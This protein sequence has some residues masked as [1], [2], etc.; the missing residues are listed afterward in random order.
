MLHA[1]RRLALPISRRRARQPQPS[2]R[3]SRSSPRAG[4]YTVTGTCGLWDPYGTTASGITVYQDCPGLW[5]RNIGGNFTTPSGQGGGW[6]FRAPAGTWI[7]S[8]SLQGPMLGTGGWQVAGYLEGGSGPGVN[9]ENC[10]GSSCPGAYKYL[11]NSYYANGASGIVMRLR[12][13][14]RQLPQQPRHHRLLRH[15]RRQRHPR[16]PQPADRRPRRRL[17]AQR[18]LEERHADRSSSTPTTTPASRSTAPHSTERLRRRLAGRLQL[19]SKGAVPERRSRRSRCQRPAWRTVRTRSAAE[20]VDASG[21]PAS[22][23]AT[24]YADNTPPTQP[25]DVAGRRRRGVARERH[26]RR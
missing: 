26:V 21:N 17:A 25:L 6:A 12:C 24:I 19:R 2:P 20:A 4:T 9:F 10:P 11:N 5:A 8:F 7:N 18:R 23:A 3:A 1:L 16:R 13:G 14:A 22:T 15:Q